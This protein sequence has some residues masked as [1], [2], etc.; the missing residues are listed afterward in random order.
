MNIFRESSD[1]SMRKIWGLMG[2]IVYL[3]SNMVVIFMAREFLLSF[4]LPTS[5]VILGFY[6]CKKRCAK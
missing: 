2:A 1:I 4:T 5:M 6:F 3:V